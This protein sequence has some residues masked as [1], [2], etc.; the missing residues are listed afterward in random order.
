MITPR[1]VGIFGI[2]LLGLG[3]IL[4]LDPTW[5]TEVTSAGSTAELLAYFAFIYAGLWGA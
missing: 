5:R 4:A 2:F 1:K 3:L